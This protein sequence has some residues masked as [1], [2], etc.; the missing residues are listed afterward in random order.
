MRSSTATCTFAKRV[1]QLADIKAIFDLNRYRHIY[2]YGNSR[3]DEIRALATRVS[4]VMRA[5]GRVRRACCERSDTFRAI[6][7]NAKPTAWTAARG[8][9]EA[10]SNYAHGIRV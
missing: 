5:P 3:N 9:I 2:V 8:R 4:L 10:T 7:L 1:R 6:R